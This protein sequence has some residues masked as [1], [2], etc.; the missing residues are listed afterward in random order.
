MIYA[1]SEKFILSL[2]HDEVVHGKGT[3]VAKMPGDRDSQLHNLR[4][5]YGYM[6]THP[7]KK[8][9]FMGQEFATYDEWNEG[10]GLDF[11]L[12]EY[13]DHY[14]MRDY[15]RDLNAFY[16]K[17]PALYREDYDVEGFSWINVELS[18]ENMIVFTRKEKES[19]ELLLVVCNFSP[20]PHE[21][22][23]VG[24]PVEGKYK[25]IFNSEQEIYGGTG[26]CNPRVK[27]SKKIKS[28]G[29]EQSIEI[30]VPPMGL[31]IFSY[32]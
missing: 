9:L 11:G 15:V 21:K 7:G 27:T 29:Q 2:S 10:E 22:Y 24:V 8:L 23:R 16:K 14:F 3:L 26:I 5:A 1:Y 4:V 32:K 17:H 20:I 19:E 25:E 28:D 13:Q 18:D 31:A 30:K 6:M 12:L